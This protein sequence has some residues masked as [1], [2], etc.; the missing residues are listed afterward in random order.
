MK[1]VQAWIV[2]TLMLC[3][4][5]VSG[6]LAKNLVSGTGHTVVQNEKILRLR[7]GHQ[8]QP[9]GPL[10]AAVEHFA[11]EVKLRSHGQIEITLVPNTANSDQDDLIALAQ[12]GKLDLVVLSV[13]MLGNRLPT[14]KIID[15]PFY[16]SAPKALHQA[17]DGDSGMRLL[18]QIH[19]LDLVGIS[20]WEEGFR[21][22]I[23][24]RKVESPDDLKKMQFTVVP[25][26]FSAKMF[27]GS[28]MIH[29]H[30]QWGTMGETIP[31]PGADAWETLLT[32]TVIDS[33]EK[34]S[35]QVIMS[36][37]AWQGAVLAMGWQGY[38]SVP[39]DALEIIKASA[40][41]IT[42]WSRRKSEQ[43]QQRMQQTLEE[44]GI[45]TQT[46][47][48]ATRNVWTN[49]ARHLALGY[50]EVLGAGLMGRIE[51]ME[52]ERSGDG[53]AWIIGVDADFSTEAMRTGLAIKRGVELAIDE[54]NGN[55]GILGKPLKVI[56]TDNRG[57]VALGV[58][59]IMRLGQQWEAVAVVAGG[60][61]AVVADQ[62]AVAKNQKML[63]LVPFARAVDW[64]KTGQADGADSRHVFRL[65]ANEYQGNLVLIDELARTHGKI[66][67]MLENS[68]FGRSAR[69]TITRQLRDLGR[70]KP[71]VV[72]F[73]LGQKVFLDPLRQMQLAEITDIFLVAGI[74]ETRQI[75][76]AMKSMAFKGQLFS[77][78]GDDGEKRKTLEDANAPDY[79]F[80]QTFSLDLHWDRTPAGETLRKRYLTLFDDPVAE[81]V[82]D[83]S[84]TAQAY[85]LVFFLAQALKRAP[86]PGFSGLEAA[87]ERL[88]AH[89]GAIKNYAWPF[90]PMR[91]EGLTPSDL[92]M[93]HHN[94]EGML[95]PRRK[96]RQ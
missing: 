15:F 10:R 62:I 48:T 35:H 89:S 63:V 21:Q 8:A 77:Y 19:T 23:T 14:F 4:L 61:D 24:N 39:T 22:L 56:T 18:Q 55:G 42:Q 50:A 51:E 81:H 37:H 66:A 27:S 75:R 91:H 49:K 58:A 87:M 45:P 26:G 11:Q 69:T 47:T 68:S 67:L 32:K 96:S 7:L 40:H 20:F 52:M 16:F 82:P 85:D 31:T 53:N 36:H 94:A 5:V 64:M 25:G 30:G 41:E 80:L 65:A 88:E 73:N 54:I 17:I 76:A 44:S 60:S 59:N 95:V 92:V 79:T 71:M 43:Q 2:G 38:P 84:A 93:V 13:S 9:D 57:S 29:T 1:P 78:H 6:F 83:P 33:L 72:W 34:K 86:D 74:E 70:E 12:Q 90:S 3:C 28:G 46:L